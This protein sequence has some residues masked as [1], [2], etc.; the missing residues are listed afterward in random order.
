MLPRLLALLIAVLA[1]AVAG[2][3]D[4]DGDKDKGQSGAPATETADD[5]GKG[6][7]GEDAEGAKDAGEETQATGPVAETVEIKETDFKLTPADP[8]VKRSG[9]IEFKV[10]NDGKVDHALEIEGPKAE[11]E[12]DT[13]KPGA[14]ATLKADLPPGTYTMYCPIGNHREQGMAGKVTVAGASSGGGASAPEKEE[15]P[16]SEGGGASSG[17]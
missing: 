12:T 11:A 13:I 16:S 7:T 3:G 5:S 14:S 4:D 6:E 1:L 9:V 8:T 10:V 15:Q 2:C 17:Y